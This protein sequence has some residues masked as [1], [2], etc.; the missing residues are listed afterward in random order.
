MLKLKDLKSLTKIVLGTYNASVTTLVYYHGCPAPDLLSGLALF[1]G[2]RNP[3]SVLLACSTQAMNQSLEKTQDQLMQR[4]KHRPIAS[5]RIS[6]NTGYGLSLGLGTAGLSLLSSF[7]LETALMGGAIWGGYIC[8]YTPLKKYTRFNTHVGSLIGALPVYLGWMAAQ[9]PLM[10]LDPLLMFVYVTAW[11]FPHFYGIAW[12]YKQDFDR[13]GFQ[14]I[15]KYDW[16]GRITLRSAIL[17]NLAMCGSVLGLAS[18]G[19][20]LPVLAPLAIWYTAGPTMVAIE[21]FQ[22]VRPR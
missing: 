12:T 15:P 13:A 14:M 16:D 20:V 6:Q 18:T 9:A 19:L 10:S 17:G 11:Q 4:T 5:G 8:L 1:S 7:S 2:S 3:Q 22:A 21:E